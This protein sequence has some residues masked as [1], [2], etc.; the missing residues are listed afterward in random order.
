[1]QIQEEK[2]GFEDTERLLA[3]VEAEIAKQE[4]GRQLQER[5]EILH[6][7]AISLSRAHQWRQALEKVKEIETLDPEFADPEG[8][9]AS[10]EAEIAREEGE[11]QRENAL[12]LMPKQCAA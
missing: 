1:V 4:A 11:A 5:V 10:A 7:Q 8:I 6:E 2:P 9:A 3:R 12:A